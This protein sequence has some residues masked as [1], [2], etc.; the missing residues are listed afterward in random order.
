M[1]AN[2]IIGYSDHHCLAVSWLLLLL[3]REKSLQQHLLL[4]LLLQRQALAERQCWQYCCYELIDLT[5]IADIEFNDRKS[6]DGQFYWCNPTE[7]TRLCANTVDLNDIALNSLAACG[8]HNLGRFFMSKL[9]I[10][11]Q[12]EY[13][14]PVDFSESLCTVLR[15]LTS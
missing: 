2:G 12:I 7:L 9:H 1:T 15:E 3:R 6:L 5:V 4:L 14:A 8:G 13:C 10:L 11:Y